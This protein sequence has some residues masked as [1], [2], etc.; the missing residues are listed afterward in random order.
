MAK[1]LQLLFLNIESSKVSKNCNR[2]KNF[3][4]FTSPANFT[5]EGMQ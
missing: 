2:K 1:I 4:F 5:F 3:D